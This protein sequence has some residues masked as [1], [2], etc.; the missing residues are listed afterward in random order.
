M[1][2]HLLSLGLYDVEYANHSDFTPDYPELDPNTGK[3]YRKAPVPMTREQYKALCQMLDE[4]Q[5][6]SR[7]TREVPSAASRVAG[8]I[9]V[10]AVLTFIAGFIAGFV[11]AFRPEKY[12]YVTGFS[13]TNLI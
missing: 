5:A 2:A 12:A 4:D 8:A 7:Y 13:F 3:F 10:V 1:C 6:E 9:Q 11:F